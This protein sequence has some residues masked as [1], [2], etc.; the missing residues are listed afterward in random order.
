MIAAPGRRLCRLL[1]ASGLL[2]WGL[3]LAAPSGVVSADPSGPS[4][5]GPAPAQIAITASGFSPSYVTVATGQTVIFTNQTTTV[6]TVSAGN[7]LFASGSIPPGGGYAVS[8]PDAT[9]VPF[10]TSASPVATGAL[11][12]GQSSI[13]GPAGDLVS[14]HVPDLGVPPDDVSTVG[15]V[16]G[17][18][19]EAPRT[20]ILV[21]F[22]PSA[23]VAQANAA[24]ASIGATVVG[25]VRDIADQAT[26]PT[27]TVTGN[28]VSQRR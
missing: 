25:T 22:D 19:V 20:Q 7:G 24:I 26:P 17:A 4:A 11:V 6:Q 12:V 28:L 21:G 5:T 2:G 16:P 18:G 3:V 1:V 23:T 9:N 15:F 8:I 13:T 27:G 10:S 14:G